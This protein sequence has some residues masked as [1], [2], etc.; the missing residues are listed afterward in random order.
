MDLNNGFR[1]AL[2]TTIIAIPLVFMYLLE[3]SS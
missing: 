2:S 1:E 3:N